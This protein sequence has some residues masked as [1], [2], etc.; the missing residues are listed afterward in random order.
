MR[1]VAK[2]QSQPI[3]SDD[4]QFDVV[5]KGNLHVLLIIFRNI[6]KGVLTAIHVLQKQPPSSNNLKSVYWSIGDPKGF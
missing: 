4:A 5:S 3:I 1:H 2:A 6:G